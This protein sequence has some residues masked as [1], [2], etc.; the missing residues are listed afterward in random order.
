MWGSGLPGCPRD[1]LKSTGPAPDINSHQKSAPER[2][3]K[4]ISRRFPVGS[5][6]H[7]LKTQVCPASG[8]AWKN[9]HKFIAV[10]LVD[11]RS[12]SSA[13]PGYLTAPAMVHR[14]TS[15][16]GTPGPSIMLSEGL[17]DLE[18]PRP[19]GNRR[20]PGFE[21]GNRPQ[22]PLRSTGRTPDINLHQKSAPET[23]SKAISRR[24][25]AG[26]RNHVLKTQV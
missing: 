2:N 26:Q 14:C 16:L 19:A 10:F 8:Q 12:L 5:K 22:D 24:F 17:K 9:I 15:R 25:P 21:P 6:N 4:A 18:G 3:S 7:V 1:P 20:S 13:L 23:N 11:R